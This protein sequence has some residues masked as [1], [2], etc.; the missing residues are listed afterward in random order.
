MKI[1]IEPHT[2]ERAAE[3]GTNEVEI[4]DVVENGVAFPA[5]YGRLAK[6]KV[7]DFNR[8][9][10]NKPYRQKKVEVYYAIELGEVFTVTVLV[11]YIN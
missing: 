1:I 11:F 7:Y 4:R 9:W 3:R 5:K 10:N 8:T 6:Y 2:L